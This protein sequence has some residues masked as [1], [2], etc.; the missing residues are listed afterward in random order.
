MTHSDR[1][2]VRGVIEQYIDGTFN[3]DGKALRACFHPN[4][5]MNGYFQGQLLLGGPEPFFEQ[6]ENNP[7][8]ADGGAPYK[9]EIT[10]IDVAGDIASV[11]LKETGFAGAMN[12]TDYFHLLKTEGEWKITSKTFISE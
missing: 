2:A 11:T 1:D 6:I 12:F 8:M 3:G 9:G 5:V 7:S 4:A 10:A